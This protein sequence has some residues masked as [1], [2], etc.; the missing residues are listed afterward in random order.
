MVRLIL[1]NER[2]FNK[3]ILDV[4]KDTPELYE[5]FKTSFDYLD[6]KIISGED[7]KIVN[8]NAGSPKEIYD[9]L[10][11]NDYV[12]NVFLFYEDINQFW[13]IYIL[14]FAEFSR[15]GY[16]KCVL[17]NLITLY[18]DRNWEANISE[19]NRN[20]DVLQ[21]YL[22]EFGFEKLDMGEFNTLNEKVYNYKKAK[23]KIITVIASA[24]LQPFLIY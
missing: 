17:E 24:Y 23:D 2:I 19:K 4:L 1:K 10:H 9:V 20:A 13:S 15:N 6:K 16:S 11:N 12:G 5:L 3:N 21:I 18:P 14:I 8:D 22:L 7:V